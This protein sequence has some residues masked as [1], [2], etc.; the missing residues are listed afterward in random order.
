[1]FADVRKFCHATPVI[2]TCRSNSERDMSQDCRLLFYGTFDMVPA[3][4]ALLQRICFLYGPYK[5]SPVSISFFFCCIWLFDLF[6]PLTA[7][8]PC[9]Y[10]FLPVQLA[11]NSKEIRSVHEVKMPIKGDPNFWVLSIKLKQVI[12]EDRIKCVKYFSI[13]LASVFNTKE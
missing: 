10:C 13:N 3:I 11:M 2:I 5:C 4:C 6:R 9:I 8:Q 12:K 7:I 1:M